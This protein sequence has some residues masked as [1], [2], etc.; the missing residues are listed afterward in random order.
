MIVSNSSPIITLGRIN[1]LDILK[2]LFYKIYIPTIVYQETVIETKIENQRKAI[3]A[4]VD[5]EIIIVTEPTTD[6]TFSR[7]L[8]KGE[9]DVLNLALE[10][11]ASAVII[12]DRKARNEARELGFYLIY[13]TDILR[14]A[15]H[16]GLITSYS[17]IMD[18]LRAMNIYLPE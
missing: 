16:R 15:E 11:R 17:E 6:H 5:A 3:L 14:G 13:T 9:M 18:Q 12:D 7:N 1:R 2:A 10:K 4:A 8:D